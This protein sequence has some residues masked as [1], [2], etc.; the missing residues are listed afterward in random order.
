[1]SAGVAARA[2][3]ERHSKS[4][5]L[6]S[7]LLPPRAGRDAA[8]VYAWCRRA[9]DAIDECDSES[10][11]EPARQALDRLRG[12]LDELY[13]VALYSVAQPAAEELVA[14]GSVVR[15]TGIPQRYPAD[16]LAGMEMDVAGYRYQSCEELLVYCYRV[17]STVGLMMC[18]VLGVS[19][20]AALRPAVHLGLAMQLT[21]I[22][23]DVA[24]DW[25]R[26]RLYLPEELLQR[27]GAGG[28]AEQ[29]GS[30]FPDAAAGACRGAM[31]E[32]LALAGRYYAS[33]DRGLEYLP[34]RC[35]LGVN[36]AR[37]IYS[38][39]GDVL[40]RQDWDPRAPRAV[41]SASHKLWSCAA[42][43]PTALLRG[44]GGRRRGARAATLSTVHHGTQLISL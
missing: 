22:C 21:N 39:I 40:A 27:H 3:I 19:D 15:A 33:S 41:V 10:G 20:A 23:R 1:M 24:E 2:S 7:R 17:A 37:R 26:G 30:P 9:D 4:F 8:A 35:A 38:A 36:A 32:L 6:A 11:S 34:F 31:I 16:L 12:E 29:L 44:S 25:R 5:S 42:A 28:L 14:F 43:V 13:S 18:H